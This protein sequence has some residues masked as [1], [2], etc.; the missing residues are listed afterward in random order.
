ML[1]LLVLWFAHSFMP[2]SA[3]Q[4]PVIEMVWSAWN[5]DAPKTKWD[6]VGVPAGGG[7][8]IVLVAGPESEVHPFLFPG[9]RAFG[10]FVEQGENAAL[11][12]YDLTTG[13]TSEM[14]ITINR[15]VTCHVS[16]DCKRLACADVVDTRYQIV[17]F[18]LATKQREVITT[19]ATYSLDPSWS[20]DGKR[21][22]YFIEYAPKIKVGGQLMTNG[23]KLAIYDFETR[24]HTLLMNEPNLRDEYGRWSPDGRWIAFT[25]EGRNP[26]RLWV[27]R[28]DGTEATEVTTGSRDDKVP[29]WSADSKT[30]AFQSFRSGVGQYLNVYKVDLATKVVTRV[31]NTNRVDEQRPLFVDR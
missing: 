2:I 24:T 30:I 11:W 8:P 31:S 28:P 17:V 5:Y 4:Q 22:S 26:F 21:R 20:P 1:S 7:R 12:K 14:G 19:H 3:L 13:R 27:V 25:R 6:I 10:Y 29:N 15:R 18:D 9:E 16:P 23:D